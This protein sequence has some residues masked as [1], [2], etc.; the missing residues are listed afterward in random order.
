M[1]YAARRALRLWYAAA[2]YHRHK[3]GGRAYHERTCRKSHKQ[4]RNKGGICR[5]Q[6]VKFNRLLL[7]YAREYVVQ[8]DH[9]SR[10]KT[11]KYAESNEVYAVFA[12]GTQTAS[13]LF[14]LAHIFP[15]IFR[16]KART[17]LQ[18]FPQSII[19]QTERFVKKI[20]SAGQGIV[21]PRRLPHLHDWRNLTIA[22]TTYFHNPP[23]GANVLF[24]QTTD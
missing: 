15:F 17:V 19:H 7:R 24:A 16:A 12:Q 14:F 6:T 21:P 4:Q 11:R 10:K 9:R 18:K 8:R 20:Y 3:S 23:S 2:A 5:N 1:K 13:A 22:Q